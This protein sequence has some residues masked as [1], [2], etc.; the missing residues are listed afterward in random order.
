MFCLSLF[1]CTNGLTRR[2]NRFDVNW[3][4]GSADDVFNIHE[5]IGPNPILKSEETILL[6][7]SLKNSLKEGDFKAVSKFPPLSSTGGYPN[8][9]FLKKSLL[10]KRNSS[11]LLKIRTVKEGEKA[12]VSF[13]QEN[14]YIDPKISFINEYQFL[15]YKILNGKKTEWHKYMA[16][17]LG[18]IGKV[19]KFKGFPDTTYYILPLFVSNYLILYKLGPPNK[20]PYDELPLAKSVGN[21]LAVPLVGYPVKY[22]IDKVIPDINNNRET[23]QS[24]PICEGIKLQHAEFIKLKL[25]DKKIFKYE[26]KPDLFP[27]DFFTLKGSEKKHSN[28]FYVRTIVKSPK[29]SIVGHQLFLPANLVEFHPASRKLDVLDASGYDLKLE[30]KLRALFIP[31]EWTDYQIKRDSENLHSYFGEE[32]KENIPDKDLRYFKIKFD[33]LVENEIE[34]AGE[35]TLK[36]V[37]ITDNYLSFNV[38]ITVKKEGAYL[39]KFAFFKKSA[40]P[41]ANYIPKQWFEEDSTLFFPTFS[42]KRR[43]YETALDYSQKDHDRFLRTT[44]FNPKSKEIKWHF[45]KQTPNDSENQ[46]V[47]TIGKLALALL[48]KAMEEAG[49]DSN[50][51]IKIVWDEKGEDKE[52]GDIRYNILNLMVTPGKTKIGLLGLGPNVAN[53]ITGEVVSATANVWVSHT[54][55][56][57]IDVVRRYIRFRL[58]SPAW[59]MEP[60]SPDMITSLQQQLQLKEKAPKCGDLYFKPLGVTTFHHE[61]IET[62]CDEVSAFIKQQQENKLTYDP[63]NPDLQDKE[64]IKSCAKKL[65][66]FPILGVILHEMLHGF[67]QR[68]V[69]SSSVDSNN[70]YTD[71]NEIKK[72]FGNLVSV[73]LKKLFGNADLLKGTNCHPHPPQYSSVMD[74]MDLFNPILFVP[75]KL[76]IA[77]LRFLYFD[78][79]DLKDSNKEPLKFLSGKDDD[80]TN[81][82]Q[83]SILETAK[84]AGY[85]RESLKNYKVLC[86]GGKLE[87]SP[88]ETNPNQPLCN[89]FDYGATPLEIVT[90][91]ILKTNNYLLNDRN[92]YDSQNI[93]EKIDENEKG[94]LSYFREKAGALYK[95]WK[96]YRDEL[97]EQKGKSIENYSFLNTAH[98]TDYE[99]IMRNRTS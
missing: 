87:N 85:L 81:I 13:A 84:D 61:K 2:S 48:N 11:S 20:I 38:E 53:P 24:E 44:R 63:E 94:K 35:K 31:V 14:I 64:I 89:R 41:S 4:Q 91:I 39:V 65:A 95:K 57:F 97:L 33:D 27:R 56:G 70:F 18:E 36:N 52:V 46:W 75:G 12:I 98:I 28:W 90:N 50:H 1:S 26:D 77:A 7:P 21:M 67:G 37:F 34:Y 23:G 10:K 54:L 51:K 32:P 74:Y 78:K 58:Y 96:Q 92:R 43:Y 76:D 72:I 93:P 86:G 3:R 19:R 80:L 68:H 5:L 45:S 22:C 15:D 82:Q 17:L 71:Y 30:D 6:P 66:F 47:R 16:Q 79:V 60:F 42:E 69:F 83:K 59:K 8:I 25:G 73:E 29:N 88:R 62:A 55:R 9:R 99:T 49:R 40:D